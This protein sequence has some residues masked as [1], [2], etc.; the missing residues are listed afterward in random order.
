[1]QV[2][3]VTIPEKQQV[4]K[5]PTGFRRLFAGEVTQPGDKQHDNGEWIPATPGYKIT[6]QSATVYARSLS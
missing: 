3:L 5:P 6:R 1:M 4:I 2:E